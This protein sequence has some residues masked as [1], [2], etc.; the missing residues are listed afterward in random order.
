MILIPI[1]ALLVGVLLGFLFASPMTPL[2]GTYLGMAVIAGLDS[3][4]GGSRSALEG[5]FQTDVFVT[6]FIANILIAFF[7]AWLGDK[8]GVNL[9]LVA[10]IVLGSRIFTNLSLMRRYA[11]T[12]WHDSRQRRKLEA[13]A[14]AKMEAESVP[15]A[16][17]ANA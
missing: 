16:P 14:A 9:F 5:K 13:E 8:I 4:T 6:G 7:L 17:S 10:A 11:L 1:V 3:V 12:R 15:S 2:L